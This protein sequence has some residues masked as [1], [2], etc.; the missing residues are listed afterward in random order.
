MVKI[1]STSFLKRTFPDAAAVRFRRT[2][3]TRR[4]LKFRLLKI[5][6]C[7][8]GFPERKYRHLIISIHEILKVQGYS[9]PLSDSGTL[10]CQAP[11]PPQGAKINFM[12]YKTVCQTKNTVHNNSNNTDD[13]ISCKSHALPPSGVRGLTGSEGLNILG[14][15]GSQ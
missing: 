15:A 8:A 3:S 12:N 14:E 1:K 7:H 11:A 6:D 2:E 4:N 5:N 13:D 9:I 10:P